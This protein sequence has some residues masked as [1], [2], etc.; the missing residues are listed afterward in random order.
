MA[1]DRIGWDWSYM[2]NKEN[3]ALDVVDGKLARLLKSSKDLKSLIESQRSD[4]VKEGVGYNVVPP[5]ADLYLSPKKDLS[6]T[7]LP[8]FVDDTVTDY[9]MPSP[10]IESTSK[11]GQNRNSSASENGEPTDSILSKPTVKFVKA[12]DRQAKRPTTNKTKTLKKP[13]VKYAEIKR[14][15]RGT[16]GSQNNAYMRPL[17]RPVGH[18]PHGAPMRPPHRPHGPPMKPMRPNM[19]GARP[20]RTTFNKQAHSYANKTFQ[21]TSVSKAS[22]RNSSDPGPTRHSMASAQ[23]SFDPAPTC[24]RMASVQDSTDPGPTRHSMASVQNSFDP[25]HTRHSMASVQ[26]STD[27]GPTRHSMA[28]A[29]NCSDPG[30]T[31]HSMASAHNSSDPGPTCQKKASVQISSDLAPECQ[32]M[33]LEH[34]S[35]SPGRNCQENVSHRDKTGT[36]SNELDLLFSLM[37]DELLNGSSKVVSKSSAVSAADAPNQRQHH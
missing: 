5:P 9:S 34:D 21:R 13:T 26:D 31:R 33:A 8:E 7:G 28:S 15:K 23:N 12:V 1:I 30:P 16:I 22:V 10:T 6:S 36:T 17:H 27:P 18:R 11:D 2:A 14:V 20:N 32:T 19:N 3:H 29:H 25:G 4:K 37:F 24:Q 35:L